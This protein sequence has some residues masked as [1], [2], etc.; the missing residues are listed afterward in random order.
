MNQYQQLLELRAS[1]VTKLEAQVNKLF[2]IPVA[3]DYLFSSGIVRWAEQILEA[4]GV[5]ITWRLEVLLVQPQR[6]S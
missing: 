3:K 6:L 2:K 1:K 4:L 5:E